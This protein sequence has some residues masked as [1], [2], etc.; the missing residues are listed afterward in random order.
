[1]KIIAFK[2]FFLAELKDIYPLQEA[3]SFYKIILNH[4]GIQQ[5]DIALNPTIELKE[6][7]LLFFTDVLN[8]LKKEI[9]I[10]YILGKTEFFGLTFKVNKNVLIPRPETEELVQWIIADCKN[11]HKS[12]IKI[13]DIGTGSGC[14]A[15]S[16]AKN[17]P[18]AQVYALDISENALSIAMENAELNKVKIEFEKLNILETNDLNQTF[19]I[20]VSNPPY[21]RL[22][23]KQQIQKNV[24][25]FEPEIAL[26]VDDEN[27]LVFYD[28]I[29]LL[30]KN[31]LTKN[32]QLYFEINQYLGNEML[33]L[34]KTH[35]FKNIK[36]KKDFHEV[37]RMVKAGF[38]V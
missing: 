21:V 6:A 37:D 28:K 2:K 25:D 17:I 15:I 9:P 3:E 16:L 32:G 23:E 38:F 30:A 36:L 12:S 7:E 34:L 18:N 10:Q 4:L 26:F 33:D 27:P 11:Y 24:L 22:Q 29:V 1:M 14:I 20:I 5:I 31:H 35:Q 13:L 19:D 8:Q